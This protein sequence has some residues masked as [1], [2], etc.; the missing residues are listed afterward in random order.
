MKILAFSDL[1]VYRA[2]AMALVEAAQGADLVIG[3]GDFAQMH[4]GLADT[5]GWLAPVAEKALYVPGN[6][7]TE[8]ALRAATDAR[9]LHGESVTINGV[10]IAG[11][12]CAIPPLPPTR[13]NSADMSEADAAQMLARFNHVDILVTHSPPKDACDAHPTLGPIGSTAVRAAIQNLRP[14]LVFCGH[15]HD[16]WGQEARIGASRVCNLGPTVN[17]FEV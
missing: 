4:D 15:I 11:I 5:M 12:G 14:K 9:V 7:E 6:N 17:W 10:T 1:H 16:C 13:W 2:A 3:A 8:A